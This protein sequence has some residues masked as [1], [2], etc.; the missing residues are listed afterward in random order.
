MDLN[1]CH[2]VTEQLKQAKH[3]FVNISGL[4]PAA[5]RRIMY[6]WT[7]LVSSQQ[8]EEES[9]F[10]FADLSITGSEPTLFCLLLVVIY[11][12]CHSLQTDMHIIYVI[13]WSCVLHGLNNRAKFS[14][15]LTLPAQ[16]GSQDN[17]L[18][19]HWP[20]SKRHTVIILFNSHILSNN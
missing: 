13:I 15:I 19:W 6:L 1:F 20:V 8:L 3:V 10:F 17:P 7:F 12:S 5:S 16:H 18:P 9:L 14:E 2:V 11:R 4:L